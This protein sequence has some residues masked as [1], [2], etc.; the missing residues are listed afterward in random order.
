ML[1]RDVATGRELLAR[2]NALPGHGKQKSQIFLA[3]LGKQYGIRPEGRRDAAGAASSLPRHSLTTTVPS[4]ELRRCAT[5][6]VD[7]RRS[8][9]LGSGGYRDA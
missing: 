3:P 4:G 6:S 8:D 7:R 9:D 1:W 2:L 5:R